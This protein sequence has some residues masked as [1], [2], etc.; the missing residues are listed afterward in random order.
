M[1]DLRWGCC[2]LH[3][4]WLDWVRFSMIGAWVSLI[5]KCQLLVG[6]MFCWPFGRPTLPW[7]HGMKLCRPKDQAAFCCWLH[8]IIFRCSHTVS[9]LGGLNVDGSRNHWEW[10]VSS[11]NNHRKELHVFFKEKN[12]TWHHDL[13]PNPLFVDLWKCHFPQAVTFS[14]RRKAETQDSVDTIPNT[15]T[16]GDC[17]YVLSKRLEVFW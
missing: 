15:E 6:Q 10:S 3:G 11:K 9:N 7:W 4:F 16:P 17:S 2:K 5:K 1:W 12:I 8:E 13:I 14:G